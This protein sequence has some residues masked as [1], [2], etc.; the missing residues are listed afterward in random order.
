MFLKQMNVGLIVI[1]ENGNE[2]RF[3]KKYYVIYEGL[4]NSSNL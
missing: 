3:G 1:Y 4:H 2:M